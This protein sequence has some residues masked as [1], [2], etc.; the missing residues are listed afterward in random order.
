M[1]RVLNVI[2]IG[3]ALKR[4]WIPIVLTVVLAASGYSVDRLHGIFAS[5]SNTSPASGI[6]SDIVA[7]NP[8]HITLEVFGAPAAVATIN[9]LDINAQPRQVIGAILPWSLTM[10][11]TQPGAFS[12]VVAQGDSDTLGCRIIV[13]NAVKDERIV[14]ETNAYTSCLVK[15]A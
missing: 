4:A 14:R 2:P 3:R 12:N 6:S 9:Y 11:T 8:K 7:F 15:S 5:H 1:V 10:V 13:D